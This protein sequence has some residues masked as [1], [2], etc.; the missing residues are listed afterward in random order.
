MRRMLKVR[1]QSQ[2]MMMLCES[3]A[4]MRIGAPPKIP[5]CKNLPGRLPRKL[6]GAAPARPLEQM[7][8]KSVPRRR[9]EEADSPKRQKTGRASCRQRVCQSEY[10][11][12]VAVS[13]NKKINYQKLL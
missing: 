6:I 10:I 5:P 9:A 7:P 4:S 13:F 3:L 12:E 2:R 11:S 1:S 8:A